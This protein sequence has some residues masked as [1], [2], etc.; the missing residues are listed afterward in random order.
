[1]TELVLGPIVGGLA[2]NKAY[3]WGK[4]DGPGVLYA[5]LGRQPDL[6]DAVRWGASMRL[7]S[8]DGYAGVAPV[9]QLTE[10]TAYYYSLSL[11][12]RS[13]GIGQGPLSQGSYPSFRTFPRPGKKTPFNFAF[14]SCFR[15]KDKDGGQILK[16]LADHLQ[17]D[18]LRF[19]ML[20]GDQI[21][22]DDYKYNSLNKTAVSLEDYRAVYKYVW[23]VPSFQTLLWN[24]PAF[25][26]LDDH[27]VDDDW[28]WLNP[29]RTKAYIPWWDQLN[30][31]LHG[32]RVEDTKVTSQK[33][34]N[35][36]Q[37]YW[38]HQGMHAPG[39]ELPMEV[40]DSGQ[41]LLTR[42]DAG[43]LAYSFTFGSAA[44]FVMDTR[45][46]RVRD[47][48]PRR[49]HEASMLGEGQWRALEAWLL[50]VKDDYPVKFLVTS[51]ALLFDLFL[52]IPRDRWSGF[53]RERRRLLSLLAA[54]G[55]EN[56]YLLAGD[57]HSTHAVKAE[58]DG[59][60]GKQIT[61]WEFCSTPLEQTPNRYAHLLYRPLNQPPIRKTD[62]KFIVSQNNFGLVRVTYDASGQPQVHFEV[63]GEDEQLLAEAG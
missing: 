14:G 51:S 45:T 21:Y 47:L 42:G 56:V 54:E 49:Q 27:E 13:P 33:I 17:E 38:E 39:F 58:L 24:L 63:Y 52:D 25:M 29:E 59:P 36:L 30:R 18:D 41:Y 3:L 46:M 44:F 40:N 48:W 4:A 10:E 55:I 7:R 32:E 12:D 57:L 50:A 22:A 34:R 37:A 11:V 35:A 16:V 5:W 62:C 23:S 1:M 60:R 31:L 20:L 2:H 61:L 26:M 43:S 9:Q 6:S 19:L 53:R 8:E 28:R 15:P